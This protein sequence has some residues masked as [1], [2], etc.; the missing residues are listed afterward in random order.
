MRCVLCELHATYSLFYSWKSNVF[1]EE[2]VFQSIRGKR[3]SIYQTLPSAVIVRLIRKILYGRNWMLT[4]YQALSSFYKLYQASTSFIKLLQTLS[5]FYKLY[6]AS[7]SF[8]NFL[9]AL[10]S[11]F[12]LCQASTNFLKLLQA[13]SSLFKLLIYYFQAS[14]SFNKPQK[15]LTS[16]SKLEKTFN[17]PKNLL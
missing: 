14:S 2:N 5:S 8:V 9:Q 16:F 17:K 1:Q 12:K 11:S 10:S 4:V 3:G 15:A 6:Q 13:F 7:S